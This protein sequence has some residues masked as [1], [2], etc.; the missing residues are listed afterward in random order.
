MHAGGERDAFTT[1]VRLRAEGAAATGSERLECLVD[2]HRDL[3]DPALVLA[4][5][6]TPSVTVAA[7]MFEQ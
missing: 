6:D 5:C 1:T 7:I 3:V 2:V 4:L